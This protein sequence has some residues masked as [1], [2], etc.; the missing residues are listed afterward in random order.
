MTKAEWERY[1]TQFE[2]I[3]D[4]FKLDYNSYKKTKNSAAKETV[5]RR[6]FNSIEEAKYLIEDNIELYK[7]ASGGEHSSAYK[8]EL[9]LGDFFKPQY[10][11]KDLKILMSK[12]KENIKNS[13]T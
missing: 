7:L 8:R 3:L 6:M 2:H 5:G 13:D 1:Y 4:E 10:F 12:I 9:I 11:G